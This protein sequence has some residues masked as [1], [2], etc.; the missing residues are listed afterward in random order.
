M[1]VV[2]YADI[3]TALTENRPYRD[4]LL[5]ETSMEIIRNYYIDK[6]G[7]KIYRILEENKESLYQICKKNSRMCRNEN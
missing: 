5:L 7:E 4:G 1:D 2:A 6:H 3:F